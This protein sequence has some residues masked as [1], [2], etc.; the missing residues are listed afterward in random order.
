M[1]KGVKPMSPAR[2]LPS[3]DSFRPWVDHS[4]RRCTRHKRR[5]W[6]ESWSGPGLLR[7]RDGSADHSN[8]RSWHQADVL[9]KPSD[10]CCWGENGGIPHAPLLQLLTRMDSLSEV[11]SL[12]LVKKIGGRLVQFRT[13]DRP[14]EYG[15]V[16]PKE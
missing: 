5:H 14:L 13:C 12:S 2:I 15:F 3:W 6:A 9:T 1:T 10:V 7:G 16:R 4:I 11:P 8:V